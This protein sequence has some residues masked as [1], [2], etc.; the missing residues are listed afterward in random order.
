[1]D[2]YLH[3]RHF[4]IQYFLISAHYLTNTY[5]I[6]LT[7]FYDVE[8]LDIIHHYIFLNFYNIPVFPWCRILNY[9][10]IKKYYW[11][12]QHL[13]YYFFY[14]NLFYWL[15]YFYHF[16]QNCLQKI[17]SHV[18]YFIFHPQMINL[19]LKFHYHLF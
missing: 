16:Y 18:H 5:S 9:N 15:H 19:F 17:L 1:M 7:K 11:Y 13:F 8:W 6:L 10:K 3:R 2:P 4:L 14:V 12:H